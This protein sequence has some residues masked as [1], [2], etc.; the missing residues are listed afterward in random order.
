MWPRDIA[1]NPLCIRVTYQNTNYQA[2]IRLQADHA[3]MNI[4]YKPTETIGWQE[5]ADTLEVV[6]KRLPAI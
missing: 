3:T 4:E 5:N 1:S 6:W 2:K